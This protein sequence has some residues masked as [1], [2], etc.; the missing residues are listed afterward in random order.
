MSLQLQE[1]TSFHFFLKAHKVEVVSREKLHGVISLPCPALPCPASPHRLRFSLLAVSV[2]VGG[3]QYLL[4]LYDT[5]GQVRH[6][7]GSGLA[8]F[9]FFS[10]L[11]W[12]LQVIR[13]GPLA[14]AVRQPA[15]R[16]VVALDGPH[17]AAPPSALEEEQKKRPRKKG[18]AP[19]GAG[20]PPRRPRVYIEK[21]HV[22]CFFFV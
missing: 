19:G 16:G 10:F 6:P 5:A 21:Q 11:L 18:P 12:I 17:C 22:C 20:D 13:A 4:G 14:E 1:W 2:T 8:S 9:P 7:A 3:K 15:W